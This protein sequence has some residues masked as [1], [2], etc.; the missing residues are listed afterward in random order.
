MPNG[1]PDCCGTCWF[2]RRNRG[3]AGY[4]HADDESIEPY[5][6]IRDVPITDP[7]YTYCANHPHRRPDRDRI[8]IGPITRPRGGYNPAYVREAWILSPDTEEIRTHLLHLLSD[9]FT[10][11]SRD[12][13][14]I[15]P[16]IGEVIVWQ[17]GEFREKR[18]EDHIKWISENYPNPWKAIAHTALEK[19]SAED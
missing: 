14:P 19:I 12:Q 6:E 10:H 11:V 5:C 17:L 2:N 4:E 1:G 13:I 8:P 9:F 3:E 16:G 18:A 7:F 15:G